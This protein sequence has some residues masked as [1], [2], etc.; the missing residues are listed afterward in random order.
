MNQPLQKYRPHFN[1]TNFRALVTEIACKTFEVEKKMD[2]ESLVP[3]Q[4]KN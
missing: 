2:I 3:D 4:A 1:I